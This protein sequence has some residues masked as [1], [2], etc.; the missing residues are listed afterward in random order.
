[1]IVQGANDDKQNVSATRGDG[2]CSIWA[3]TNAFTDLFPNG[4]E[5]RGFKTL[6]NVIEEITKRLQ[7]IEGQCNPTYTD[8]NGNCYVREL[9][10]VTLLDLHSNAGTINGEQ[11]LY[12]LSTLLRVNISICDKSAS[13]DIRIKTIPPHGN[14]QHTL[15]I[16]TDGG[17]YNFH[18]QTLH[19]LQ[20]G[21]HFKTTKW[22]LQQWE[23]GYP[24][25]SARG[26]EIVEFS[27][28]NNL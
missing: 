10:N 28:G 22:F 19:G 21:S 20:N 3:I 9:I 12:S 18:S 4:L 17:H 15:Y 5:Q 11:H 13:N 24:L 14:Y 23:E 7:V 26:D 8:N 16:S 6:R 27:Y 2:F 25:V 1:M